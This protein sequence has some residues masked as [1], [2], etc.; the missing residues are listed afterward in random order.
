MATVDDA[1]YLPA[2]RR[3]LREA[4]AEKLLEKDDEHTLIAAWASRRDEQA[5]HRLIRAHLRLVVSIAGRFRHYGLSVSDLIQEGNVGLMLAAERFDNTRDV[6]FSTYAAWWVKSCIQDFVLRNWSIVRNGTTAAHKSLFFNLRRLR[7]RFEEENGHDLNDVGRRHIA[8]TLGVSLK[9][10]MDVES[11]LAAGDQSL[12][13]VCNAEGDDTTWQDLLPDQRPTP[14][15]MLC[16]ASTRRRRSAWLNQAL[17]ALNPREQMI[18]HRR[19]LQEEEG[20]TLDELGRELG[21]SKERVRQVENRALEKI[22][23]HLFALAGQKSGH[24][25]EMLLN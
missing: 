1:D 21:I 11:R 18:I 6:R 15:D 8:D 25:M 3:F 7:S 10:V 22:R 14:E 17:A 5:L 23:D 4:M 2:S 12:S 13:S 9:E 19:K 16:D 20:V 24:P